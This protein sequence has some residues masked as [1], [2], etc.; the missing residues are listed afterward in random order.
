MP[1]K[2][3]Q[4]TIEIEWFIPARQPFCNKDPL[5]VN[6][7]LNMIFLS[8]VLDTPRI[9]DGGWIRENSLL[10]NSSLNWH[11]LSSYFWYCSQF[12]VRIKMGGIKPR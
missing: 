11:E 12:N 6:S 8:W 10:L 3:S 4:L 5:R 1:L 2:L 7:T 9:L